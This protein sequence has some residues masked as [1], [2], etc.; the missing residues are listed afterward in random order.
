MTARADRQPPQNLDAEKSVLGSMLVDRA[1]IDDVA[2]LLR[3]D[4]FHRDGHAVL[5]AEILA[6]HSEGRAVDSIT[7]EDVLRGKGLWDRIGGFDAIQDVMGYGPITVNAAYHASIVKAHA[8]RREGIRVANELLDA[9]YEA[10]ETPAAPIERATTELLSLAESGAADSIAD[11]PTASAAF[12]ALMERRRLGEVEG[13]TTGFKQ[14]DKK[15]GGLCAPR[16]I[17]LAGRPAHGKTG[18]ALNIATHVAKAGG[19]V[20]FVSQEMGQLELFERLVSGEGLIDNTH[21][22][23]IAYLPRVQADGVWRKMEGA[24]GRIRPIP[25]WIDDTPGR[26]AVQIE[27]A[28]RRMHGRYGLS[29]LVV[30]YIQLLEAEHGG[31]ESRQEQVSKIS[32]R[33]KRIAMALKIPVL[34]LAQLNRD[35]EKREDRVPRKSDLRETGALEQDADQVILIHRPEEYDAN[36]RPGEADLI[37][38]KNR[39]GPVGTVTVNFHGPTTSFSPLAEQDEP[40][41]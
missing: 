16:M 12:K 7:I 36:D 11:M 21:L 13:L 17:I 32:R 19:K 2:A 5:Y 41:F 22:R 28:A 20:L 38:A 37:L 27:S 23:D 14:L 40:D 18:I 33:M 10:D 8:V 35:V 15:T 29:L 9:C 4:D 26:T 31:R 34:V 30:D 1:V 6:A 25:L 3:P 24:I 39:F